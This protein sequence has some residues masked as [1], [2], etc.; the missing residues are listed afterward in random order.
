MT[1]NFQRSHRNENVSKKIYMRLKIKRLW[2][3]KH[4]YRKESIYRDFIHSIINYLLKMNISER[5]EKVNFISTPCDR[6]TKRSVIEQEVVYVHLQMQKHS[7][8]ACNS[9]NALLLNRA[10]MHLIL[11]ISSQ[12]HSKDIIWKQCYI[13]LCF[14]DWSMLQ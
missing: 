6:S 7:S 2:R 1:V 5:L 9:L 11:K 8:H 3:L 4:H 13:E 14:Y 10:K 12:M